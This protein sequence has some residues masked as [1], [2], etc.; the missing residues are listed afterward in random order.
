MSLDRAKSQVGGVCP[1]TVPR[2]DPPIA[3]IMAVN[4]SEGNRPSPLVVSQ[5]VVPLALISRGA[6]EGTATPGATAFEVTDEPSSR[7][8]RAWRSQA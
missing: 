4:R 6:A 3:G 2:L 8:L 5:F 1:P 7:G